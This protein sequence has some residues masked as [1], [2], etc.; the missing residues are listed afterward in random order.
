MVL[1][2][3]AFG[4]LANSAGFLGFE[5]DDVIAWVM[6]SGNHDAASD[7]VMTVVAMRVG[8]GR[9]RWVDGRSRMS[10][11]QGSAHS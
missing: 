7:G 2:L 11:T 4:V 9:Y 10:P 5:P 1:N 3:A 6:T 8:E